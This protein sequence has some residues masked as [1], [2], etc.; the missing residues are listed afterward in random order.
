MKNIVVPAL[1]VVFNNIGQV[2]LSKRH[3]P[4]VEEWHDKWQFPGGMIEFGETP[5]EA[6]IRET[7]EE[8]GIDIELMNLPPVV[9][10]HVYNNDVHAICIAYS[11]LFKSGDLDVSKDP[12]TSEAKWFSYEEIDFENCLP[13]TKEIIDETQKYITN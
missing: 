2:L 12:G 11:A 7:K 6:A 3:Q 5:K 8:V 4:D 9:V 1:A 13:L 10:S